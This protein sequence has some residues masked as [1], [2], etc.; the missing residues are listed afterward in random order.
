LKNVFLL[1]SN[2]NIDYF[3]TTDFKKCV[4]EFKECVVGGGGAFA[5]EHTCR[6]E[7]CNC[8]KI[9]SSNTVD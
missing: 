8:R 1:Y 2:S 5:D 4:K 6:T 9:V 3:Y 7:F